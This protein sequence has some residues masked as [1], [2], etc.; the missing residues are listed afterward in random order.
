MNQNIP[1][2]VF[3]Y[4]FPPSSIPT[5]VMSMSKFPW[6][7]R[8]K[9]RLNDQTIGRLEKRVAVSRG[10]IKRLESK[11]GSIFIFSL[12]RFFFFPS[13][14]R[15]PDACRKRHAYSTGRIIR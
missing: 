2:Q 15:H 1:M 12:F 13:I 5:V 11:V 9:V 3:F 6:R 4:E 8:L 14:R 7:E 10:R